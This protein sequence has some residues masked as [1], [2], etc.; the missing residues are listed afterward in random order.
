[1]NQRSA[2][3]EK[4]RS[5]SPRRGSHS[6][7]SAFLAL[8]G[9][10]VAAQGAKGGKRNNKKKGNGKGKSS[11]SSQPSSSSNPTK[12]FQY[13]MKLPIDFRS[14]FHER[15][16]KK[17]ICF[18]FQR[19]QCRGPAHS[20]KFAHICVECGGPKPYD[21]CLCLSDSGPHRPV[22]AWPMLDPSP[23]EPSR[24]SRKLSA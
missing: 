9:P 20:C 19:G 13:L 24:E 4:A 21:E 5:R 2:D 12:N 17:E 1:M 18:P 22:L 14:Q 6:K 8:P 3:L 7:R 23:K 10:S 11:S 16:H 15:F